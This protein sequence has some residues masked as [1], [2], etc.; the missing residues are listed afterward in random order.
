MT[1]AESNTRSLKD[2]IEEEMVVSPPLEPE[3][4]GRARPVSTDECAEIRR[5]RCD[6]ETVVAIASDLDINDSTVSRHARGD[7]RC[8][9]DPEEV[10]SAVVGEI[11]AD[12]CAEIRQRRQAGETVTS[13]ADSFGR[14][15]TAIS[16]HATGAKQCNHDPADVGEPVH[17]P[18]GGPIGHGRGGVS[19]GDCA[20]IRARRRVGESLTD[21]AELLD[22]SLGTISEHARGEDQCS[23]D[24]AVVGPP[25][26]SK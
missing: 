11:A 18:G 15:R 23:H 13:I 16:R 2:R 8:S 6:G 25:V 19:P 5:R 24:P 3:T 21:V 17:G 26:E 22:R 10:G 7:E 20:S 4:R 1:D 12:E 9:H 14:T